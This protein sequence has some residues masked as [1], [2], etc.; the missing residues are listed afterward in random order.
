MTMK[1]GLI[2]CSHAVGMALFEVGRIGRVGQ[3]GR[4]Q[5]RE[6]CFRR[7]R[8]DDTVSIGCGIRGDGD[9]RR[10]VGH[11]DRPAEHRRRKRQHRAQHR[12]VAQV[13]MPV[14]GTANGQ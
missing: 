8:R 13:K 7:Q 3:I 5:R 14:V 11:D 1:M 6:T 9:G 10:Q 2:E 4:H 12:I